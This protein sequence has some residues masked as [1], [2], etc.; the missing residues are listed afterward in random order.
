MLNQSFP[1]AY[2][3]IIYFFS[4]ICCNAQTIQTYSG[5]Y[6]SLEKSALDPYGNAVYTYYQNEKKRVFHGKFLYS[7]KHTSLSG[8]FINNKQDGEW[9]YNK[10]GLTLSTTIKA[11]FKNGIVDGPVSIKVVDSKTLELKGFTKAHVKNNKIVGEISALPHPSMDGV[12]NSVYYMPYFHRITGAFNDSGFPI[13]TWIVKDNV[14]EL[15]EMFSEDGSWEISF[16]NTSTGD[17]I[18]DNIERR[19][20]LP[21]III[22]IIKNALS[23]LIMRDTECLN[24]EYIEFEVPSA[25]R[26]SAKS[27]MNDRIRNVFQPQKKR[28]D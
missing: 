23:K 11:S 15:K 18:N 19:P 14:K 1:L 22:N 20:E 2:F 21:N 8:S 13:G 5:P 28:T 26:Q 24:I 3:L 9:T 6:E 17:I 27:K 25:I 16:I 7:D 12:N 10:K 4:T